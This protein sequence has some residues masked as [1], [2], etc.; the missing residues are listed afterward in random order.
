MKFLVDSALSP[1][2]AKQL[3]RAGHDAIH[4]RELALES[5]DDG[6]VFERAQAEGRTGRSG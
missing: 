6:V 5:A 2:V 4:V 1:F 3:V